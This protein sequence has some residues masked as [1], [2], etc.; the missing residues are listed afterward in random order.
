MEYRRLIS[1]ALFSLVAFFSFY[2]LR[3]CGQAWILLLFLCHFCYDRYIV[4]F[5]LLLVADHSGYVVEDFGLE[6]GFRFVDVQLRFQLHYLL[7]LLGIFILKRIQ[8]FSF[9]FE[10]ITHFVEALRVK[11]LRAQI[12]IAINLIILL[13]LL[14][15]DLLLEF[16]VLILEE[17]HLLV[18]KVELADVVHNQLM[19]LVEAFILPFKHLV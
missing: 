3:C 15:L 9:F 14:I 17:V 12:T 8:Q 16:P 19:Q 4:I 5:W 10:D 18:D 1:F 11:F 2:F 13:L 7:H 6:F